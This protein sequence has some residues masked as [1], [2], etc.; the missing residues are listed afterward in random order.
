MSFSLGENEEKAN[1]IQP[2]LL[3]FFLPSQGL[4]PKLCNIFNSKIFVFLCGM[5]RGL[6][7]PHG[8]PLV[9]FNLDLI[10]GPK[11]KFLQSAGTNAKI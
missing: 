10:E 7:G 1:T 2:P 5:W 8:K 6:I 11:P 4:I 9:F 3:V